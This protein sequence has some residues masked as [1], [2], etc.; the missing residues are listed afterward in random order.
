MGIKMEDQGVC[1]NILVAA[2]LPQSVMNVGLFQ[3]KFKQ[4]GGEVEE[5]E[6]PGVSKKQHVEFP[7]VK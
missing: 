1:Q 7:R 5:K 6:F 2:A 4:G 3:K